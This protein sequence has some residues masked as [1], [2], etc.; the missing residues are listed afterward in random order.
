VPLKAEILEGLSERD[1]EPQ[2]ARIPEGPPG[3]LARWHGTY[4]GESG[5]NG[6]DRGARLK[7]NLG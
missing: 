3:W 6:G 1:G 7:E 5:S 2:V 4:S